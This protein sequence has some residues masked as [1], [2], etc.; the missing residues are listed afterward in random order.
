[1]GR[2]R[3]KKRDPL[4]TTK[5]RW[6]PTQMPKV[7]TQKDGKKEKSRKACRGRNRYEE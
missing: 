4:K 3:K 6:D 5:P 1:M 2:K 7:W